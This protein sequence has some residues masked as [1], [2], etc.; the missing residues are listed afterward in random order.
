[1]TSP[2]SRQRRTQGSKSSKSEAAS[3]GKRAASK[4]AAVTRSGR[5]SKETKKTRLSS[6]PAKSEAKKRAGRASTAKKAASDK[7]S[8]TM[9][10]TKKA[11]GRARVEKPSAKSSTKAKK[12]TTPE[13]AEKVKLGKRFVAQVKTR[14]EEERARLHAQLEELERE[15]QILAEDREDLDDA[16]TE[17]SGQG[18]STLAEQEREESV[19]IRI[20]ELLEKVERALEKLSKGKYGLCERCGNQ[21]EKARLEA[22]PY[23]ELCIECKR[24]EERRF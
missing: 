5:E 19:A 7:A 9:S 1:M 6:P 17:E 2:G 4:K 11:T 21:I 16:F 20:R 8:K 14:L 10:R 24:K 18:A 15:R 13:R 3:T 23:A 22:L 12:P